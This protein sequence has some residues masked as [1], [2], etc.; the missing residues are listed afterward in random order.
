MEIPISDITH[1]VYSDKIVYICDYRITDRNKKPIR[2]V[3]PTE[4][5]VV[6]KTESKKTVYYSDYCFKPLGVNGKP[7][8]KIIMPFDNT[9]YRSFTGNPVFVFDNMDECVEKWNSMID[10]HIQYWENEKLHAI[11]R[12]DDRI[13]NFEDMLC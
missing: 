5:L 4:V 7:L 9:G 8:S 11:Q 3:S 1:G 6:H 10:E 2:N 12:I 13:A